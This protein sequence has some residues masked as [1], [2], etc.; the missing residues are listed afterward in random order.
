[1]RRH[2]G[3]LFS[4]RRGPSPRQFPGWSDS[5]STAIPDAAF[6]AALM[7]D[8]GQGAWQGKSA[9]GTRFVRTGRYN[10]G[11]EDASSFGHKLRFRCT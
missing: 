11:K 9:V 3:L 4:A 5:E 1:M 2:A 6:L 8:A 10:G 7:M